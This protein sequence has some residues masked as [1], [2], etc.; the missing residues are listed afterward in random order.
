[1]FWIVYINNLKKTAHQEYL[2]QLSTV[3]LKKKTEIKKKLIILNKKI[4]IK[5]K[6]INC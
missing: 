2:V 3:N 5:V 4:K 1:M 6:T